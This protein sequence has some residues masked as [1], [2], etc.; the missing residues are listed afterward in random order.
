MK[1][2]SLSSNRLILLAAAGLVAFYN[3]AFFRILLDHY[4]PAD[5][6]TGFIVAV[7]IVAFALTA[8]LLALICIGPLTRPALQLLIPLA[9]IWA[10]F[11]DDYGVIFDREML[12]NVFETDTREA[13][14]LVNFRFLAYLV[15]LGVLPAL[16][17]TRVQVRRETGMRLV[18]GR[19]TLLAFLAGLMAAAIWAYGGHFGSF[20]R[21]HKVVRSYANPA[22]PLVSLLKLAGEVFQGPSG[23]RKTVGE[24]AALPEW[25][26]HR[27]LVVF[28]LGETARADHFSLNGY[29]RDTNPALAE[30]N[31]ISLENFWSC[32]TSTAYAVPCLFSP[33]QE[34]GYSPALAGRSDNVL[35]IL[36]RAGVNVLWIDNNSGSKGVADRVEYI[37]Y[38]AGHPQPGCEVDCF[39]EGMLTL[40]PDYIS[41]HPDGDILIVLHQMGSH[42]PAYYKR[43]PAAFERFSPACRSTQLESCSDSE[44]HNAYD[45]SILYTDYFLGRVI[46]LLR[47]HD[48]TF[49]TA[50]F[51]VSDHGESLGEKGLYLH[52]MPRLVAPDSQRHVPAVLW[53]GDNNDDADPERIRKSRHLRFSH[54]NVFHTLLGFMEVQTAAYR[55]EM[56]ILHG[57][58]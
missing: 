33:L 10:G 19:L 54:D 25:D 55:Q 24:D 31:V 8:F 6:E 11:M 26:S 27:E 41:A 4:P 45:N 46:E 56:D 16:W 2:I 52:G 40:I 39:D 9:A 53:F 3:Q 28:V 17:L 23:P 13:M 22:Y 15:L 30:E 35:D 47:N 7:G 38:A 49:E 18:L 50:L 58:R 43:Y 21:E 5:T 12:R 42:G 1:I 57:L 29:P 37:D 14:D 32:G 48:E 44:I 20:F 34:T 51:Y 36:V